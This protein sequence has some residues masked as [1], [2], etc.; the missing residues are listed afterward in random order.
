MSVRIERSR[1]MAVPGPLAL[2]AMLAILR[3]LSRHEA[4]YERAALSLGFDRIGVPGA[5][6]LSVPVTLAAEAQPQRYEC[7]LAI[8]AT[9]TTKLFPTFAGSISVSPMRDSGSELWLQ[10]AYSVP[11]GAAGQFVDATFLH[12][13]A[14]AS[15]ER[16]ITWLAHEIV[17]RVEREQRADVA[18]RAIGER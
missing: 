10:G 3:A 11:F 14:D 1:P 13:A 6:E 15:L 4:P 16:F 8:A 5:G 2:E 7:E 17:T 9:A 18:G 12:H